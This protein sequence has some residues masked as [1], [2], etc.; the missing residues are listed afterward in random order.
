MLDENP[1]EIVVSHK[2]TYPRLCKKDLGHEREAAV[3]VD[4]VSGVCHVRVDQGPLMVVLSAR[5]TPPQAK[6]HLEP[7]SGK[8][9]PEGDFID[10]YTEEGI[11]LTAKDELVCEN[12]FS[13]NGV[14]NRCK[15]NSGYSC[16]VAKI[17]AALKSVI[18]ES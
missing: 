18:E 14:S 6:N 12:L 3:I 16:P 7:S 13:K 10:E 2:T 8:G 9:L 15:I 4:A 1:A 5:K 11:S 17:V